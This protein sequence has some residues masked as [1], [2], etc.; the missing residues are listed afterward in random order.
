VNK[1]T[2]YLKDSTTNI[3][4]TSIKIVKAELDIRER[5]INNDIVGT[6]RR[7]CYLLIGF[8]EQDLTEIEFAN[9]DDLDLALENDQNAGTSTAW[10]LIVFNRGR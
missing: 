10:E 4:S 3:I 8:E 5:L 6:L 2:T 9:T 1:V 7:N